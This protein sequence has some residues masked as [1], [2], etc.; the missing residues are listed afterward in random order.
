M[1]TSKYGLLGKIIALTFVVAAIVACE[2]SAINT[3]NLAADEDPNIVNLVCT[4]E[5]W[6][7]RPEK[8]TM[9][10]SLRNQN[11]V[12]AYTERRINA[13]RVRSGPIESVDS[14]NFFENL[15][16]NW[17]GVAQ[18]G[19]RPFFNDDPQWVQIPKITPEAYYWGEMRLDRASLE[20]YIDMGAWRNS[21]LQCRPGSLAEASQH[22]KEIL[23]EAI[24]RF[25]DEREAGSRGADDSQI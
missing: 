11:E 21:T 17:E 13:S 24:R 7:Y 15:V 5:I 19:I 2:E 18:F 8:G 3:G 1:I 6:Q 12:G 16:S 25:D 4:G 10:L 20:L 23:I 9:H 22:E 14:R